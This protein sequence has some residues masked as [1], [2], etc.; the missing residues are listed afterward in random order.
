[1]SFGKHIKK[2]SPRRATLTVASS[3]AGR[4]RIPGVTLERLDQASKDPADPHSAGSAPVQRSVRPSG[5]T[6]P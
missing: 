6:K 1:M 5:P 2:N 4:L 3:E